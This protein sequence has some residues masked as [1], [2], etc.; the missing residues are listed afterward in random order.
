M[1]SLASLRD[2]RD[3]TYDSEPFRI[4]LPIMV[5]NVIFNGLLMIDNVMFSVLGN[6][7]GVMVGSRIGAGREALART[8]AN[9]SMALVALEEAVKAAFG[10]WRLYTG[11]WLHNLVRGIQG[12]VVGAEVRAA[13]GG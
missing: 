3:R 12:A 8:Y 4:G 10:L 11:R 13:G 1:T 6:A 9:H 5:Q 7:Y 2:F